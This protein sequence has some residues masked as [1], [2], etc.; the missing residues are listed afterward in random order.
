MKVALCDND[1]LH[2]LSACRL[3]DQAISALGLA[4][5]QA[6]VLPTARY[7]FDQRKDKATKKF[8]AEVLLEIQRVL[9][10]SAEL[11]W[12]PPGPEQQV[13]A[14]VP[15]ID[16]GEAILFLAAAAH[17]GYV[18]ATGDKRSLRALTERA[19]CSGVLA[20]LKGR[21]VC[22]EQLVLRLIDVLG[23]EEVRS[24]IVPA[25]SCDNAL[26]VAFGAGLGTSEAN[27][28]EALENYVDELRGLP[29]ELLV[30]L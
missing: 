1:I 30:D 12:T 26:R 9:A 11:N 19:E 4:P 2:K 20:G 7:V 5:Q 16:T 25:L 27:A 6:M 22:L 10:C 24:R 13:L 8:G 29:G 14:D 15:G 28:K 18:L 3:F 21:V 17:D 23:F